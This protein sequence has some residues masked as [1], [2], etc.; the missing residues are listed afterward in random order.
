MDFLPDQEYRQFRVVKNI[1]VYDPQCVLPQ[2]PIPKNVLVYQGTSDETES[3]TTGS[4]TEIPT[5]KPDAHAFPIIYDSRNRPIIFR[6]LDNN[7]SIEPYNTSTIQSLFSPQP[8]IIMNNLYEENP[9]MCRISPNE[10]WNQNNILFCNDDPELRSLR[11]ESY[12]LM[13]SSRYR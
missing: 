4:T 7:G 2:T 12:P 10:L 3:Y 1:N 11:F 13:P 6:K 5:P 8:C 9:R